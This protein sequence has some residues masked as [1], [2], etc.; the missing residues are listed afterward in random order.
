M[1]IVTAAA[2]DAAIEELEDLSEDRY[3]QQMQAF[4]EAQPVVIAYLFSDSFEL[5]SEEERG[6]LQYLALIAW[7]AIERENGRIEP[8]SEEQI[9]EAEERNYEMLENAQGAKFSDRL[10]TFFEGYAQEDLLAFAEEAVIEEEGEEDALVT[11]EGRE[12]LFVALKTLID[13]MSRS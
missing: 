12:T 5:L 3:E 2:I 11:R 6:Y 10:E 8:V 9:G 4:A 1:K 13:A 7:R